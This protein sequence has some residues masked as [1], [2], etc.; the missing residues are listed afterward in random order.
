MEH[1]DAR[2]DVARID[3]EAV[4][5]TFDL[6]VRRGLDDDST[7]VVVEASPQFVR[8]TATNGGWSEVA[9]SH[10]DPTCAEDVITAQI[11]HFAERDQSFAWRLYDY[12]QPPDL[13]DRLLNAGFSVAGHSTL[14]VADV[15]SVSTTVELPD[16]VRLVPV[17]DEAGVNRLIEVHEK[18]F[19][20]DHSHLRRSI[21][22]Q[23]EHSPL[24]AALV[25]AMVDDLAVSS[26]RVEFLPARI[27]AS[28][29]GGGTLSD[30]RGRGLYRA[31]VAYRAQLA[32]ERG[33]KYVYATSSS[34]SRPILERLGFVAVS[35][36]TTYS[37]TPEGHPRPTAG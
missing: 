32:K 14:V 26:A 23:L 8:W 25:V 11:R 22:T 12:D 7:G 27:F 37:W 34:E 10:L 2:S 21:M 9:W 6:Q 5:G 17:D 31:L 3:P 16:R 15:Q 33:Y 20:T 35:A 28:L 4:R 30:W 19:G 36:I 18:V 29:W 1:N 13:G 24:V